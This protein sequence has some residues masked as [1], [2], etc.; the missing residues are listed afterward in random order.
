M[1][2]ELKQFALIYSKLKGLPEDEMLMF[3]GALN[4]KV[5]E[6]LDTYKEFVLT[7]NQVAPQLL[8]LNSVLSKTNE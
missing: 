2:N 4:H 3:I 8:Q 7:L 5:I 6:G 1:N